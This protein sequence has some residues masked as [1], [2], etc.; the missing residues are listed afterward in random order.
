MKL[1][2]KSGKVLQK[3]LDGEVISYS[4]AKSKVIDKLISENILYIKGKHRRTVE[5]VDEVGLELFLANQLQI[6]DLY[7][8]VA[9]LESKDSSRADFMQSARDS[10]FSKE[11][12]FKGFLINSYD[13]IYA[14]LNNKD[15]LIKPNKGSFMF[16]YDFESFEIPND[17]VIVGIENAENFRY[18]EKQKYLFKNIKPLF[19]SRYPQNQSKDFILWMNSIPNKYLHFGDFDIAGIG[20]YLNEY[21]K[22]LNNKATFFI[23]E[24]VEEDIRNK[25]NIERYNKQQINFDVDSIKEDRLRRLLDVIHFEKKGLDQEYYIR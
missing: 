24:S 22:Y 14:K 19:V 5:L 6:D 8:Y 13:V 11:R 1:N 4:S 21:K 7:G 23:P 3:L 2:L 17:I 10:K 25:G 18:I 9:A 12:V 15:F 20:I 16:V